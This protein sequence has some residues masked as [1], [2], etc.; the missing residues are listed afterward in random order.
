MLIHEV[1]TMDSSHSTRIGTGSWFESVSSL[2]THL[3]RA[4]MLQGAASIISKLSCTRVCI[5]KPW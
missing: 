4:Q 2:H 3:L 1:Y 5:T